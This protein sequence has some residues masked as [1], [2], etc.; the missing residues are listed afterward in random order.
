L[1]DS[2]GKRRG[3]PVGVY[4]E[5]KHPS[6]FRSIGLP[7][8]DRLL[9]ALRAHGLDRRESPVFIQSFE[10]ANLRALRARTKVRLV[11]LVTDTAQVTPLALRD[12]A[13]YADAIGAYSRL[14]VPARPD[15]PAT[16]LVRDAHAAG[17]LIHVWTLRSEAQFL[18]ARYHG[19][20]LGEVRELA[21]LGVDG[22][23]GDFP[24]VLLKGLGRQ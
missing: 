18:A 22:I 2:A 13:T 3:R 9:A 6:Y 5:T 23:F 10:S 1:A 20:P 16:S 4:P 19:D 21:A 8:E 7:L 24:D 15:A 14:V 12:I 11:Q 17:L